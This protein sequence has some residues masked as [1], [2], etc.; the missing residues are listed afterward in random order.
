[1]KPITKTLTVLL[2]LA[3]LSG[4]ITI[5]PMEWGTIGDVTPHKFGTFDGNSY[6]IHQNGTLWIDFYQPA[7]DATCSRDLVLLSGL[8][9]G[10]ARVN[11]YRSDL[12]LIA[13]RSVIVPSWADY[14]P[15]ASAFPFSYITITNDYAETFNI[16]FA[17]CTLDY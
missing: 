9:A 1:M 17:Y 10:V 13:T 14:I 7:F 4:W 15:V 16:R 2:L 12:T 3:L 11:F 8:G 6:T 5:F